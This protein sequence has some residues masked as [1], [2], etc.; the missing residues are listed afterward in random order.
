MSKDAAPLY[1][2]TTGANDGAPAQGRSLSSSSTPSHSSSSSGRQERD[3]SPR[4]VPGL[5]FAIS[6]FHIPPF[7]SLLEQAS[8]MVNLG[9]FLYHQRILKCTLAY[10]YV[11]SLLKCSAMFVFPLQT[12][13]YPIITST[14]NNVRNAG[15][16]TVV[17]ILQNIFNKLEN[18]IPFVN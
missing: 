9:P 1:V 17:L 2:V 16:R 8:F 6:Q 15:A 14:T 12:N 18:H 7:L 10:L 4:R 3:E 13:I 5:F 11:M